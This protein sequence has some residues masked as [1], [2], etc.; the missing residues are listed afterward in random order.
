MTKKNRIKKT[1]SWILTFMFAQQHEESSLATVVCWYWDGS[2]LPWR[3]WSYSCMHDYQ[4]ENQSNLSDLDA[5]CFCLPCKPALSYLL[6]MGEVNKL[7]VALNFTS[8]A[9]TSVGPT[10][11]VYSTD[12]DFFLLPWYCRSVLYLRICYHGTTVSTATSTRI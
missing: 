3:Q 6:V 10:T 1:S 7:L 5:L 8:D 9:Q 2:R 4:N 11:Y 12:V